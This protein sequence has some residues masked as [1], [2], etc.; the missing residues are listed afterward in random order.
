MWL[1]LWVN[2]KVYKNCIFEKNRT[3]KITFIHLPLWF[4]PVRYQPN[5]HVVAALMLSVRYQKTHLTF[6]L[7]DVPIPHRIAQIK[8]LRSNQGVLGVYEYCQLVVLS[9][10]VQFYRF[11]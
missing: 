11:K 2:D 10:R 4:V 1:R 3:L 7:F 6:T 8:V 9:H 5:I